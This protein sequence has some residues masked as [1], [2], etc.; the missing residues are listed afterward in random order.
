MRWILFV[1]TLLWLG[2]SYEVRTADDLRTIPANGGGSGGACRLGAGG[3]D[4]I[5][6]APG[7]VDPDGDGC[8]RSCDT[9]CP[10]FGACVLNS[11]AVATCVCF[12]GVTGEQCDACT[13]VDPSGEVYRPWV[14]TNAN[15]YICVASCAAAGIVCDRCE[16]GPQ[17]PRCA[18][19]AGQVDS[20]GD[21]VCEP[22][23]PAV[24]DTS[25]GQANCPCAAGTIPRTDGTCASPCGTGCYDLPGP[26]DSTVPS[27]ACTVF[28]DT[29]S[30]DKGDGDTWASA[31]A[32]L[33]EALTA[34]ANRSHPQSQCRSVFIRGDLNMAAEGATTF[35]LSRGIVVVGGFDA[36]MDDPSISDWLRA[37]QAGDLSYLPKLGG[38][39]EQRLTRMA[40]YVV[41]GDGA[42]LAGI[43]LVPPKNVESNKV[44]AIEIDPGASVHLRSV[45]VHDFS[46]LAVRGQNV[47]T[48]DIQDSIF[49]SNV[50][51]TQ[52]TVA[53]ISS[54]LLTLRR[55][56][57]VDNQAAAGAAVFA[58]G[59]S[60]HSADSFFSGNA[61]LEEGGALLTQAGPAQEVTV[62]R[63]VFS[64]NTAAVG[65]AL[66][67]SKTLSATPLAPVR[68]SSSLFVNNGSVATEGTAI[69][70]QSSLELRRSTLI[71]DGPQMPNT[72]EVRLGSL[73]DTLLGN[74]FL[75]T[76]E[77]GGGFVSDAG[78]AVR[79]ERNVYRGGRFCTSSCVG[80]EAEALDVGALLF[81]PK[82]AELSVIGAPAL[83]P[84]GERLTLTVERDALVPPP[85]TF[86]RDTAKPARLLPV[87]GGGDAGVQVFA[88]TGAG[89]I[90][91]LRVSGFNPGFD[92]P[93]VD[94]G[95]GSLAEADVARYDL[96]GRIG[97]DSPQ[98]RN[99]GAGVPSYTDVGCF[100]SHSDASNLR[101]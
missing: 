40:G 94:R 93:L 36:S 33:N 59:T 85:G 77:L 83:M 25:A 24:C 45:W 56:A 74:L 90:T 46:L 31:Y 39:A 52:G 20:D 68:V 76:A 72:A 91:G 19:P 96:G 63:C 47:G 95:Y 13:A 29:T 6:C 44:A 49:S 98:A 3:E 73:S 69:A 53:L 97:S 55:C 88:P 57:F 87:V 81:G 89:G 71:Q 17:G 60:L 61:A 10:E 23:L 48:V 1:M 50:S 21:G 7:F 92:S 30:P 79:T 42:V 66:R 15:Q 38:T 70:S 9:P 14:D 65:G 35:S 80:L 100:E 86:V 22:D 99:R 11:E 75:S 5:A 78:G 62:E 54:K 41:L 101:N 82:P 67:F 8:R 32:T 84:A 64:G 43:E 12:G 2:C 16:L 51:G 34:M 4:C 37:R 26:G 28:V 27:D 18:C 58:R